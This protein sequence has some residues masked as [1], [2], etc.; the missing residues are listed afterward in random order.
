MN[1]DKIPELHRPEVKKGIQRLKETGRLEWIYLVQMANSWGGLD[2]TPA[3]EALK[4]T[5]VRREILNIEKYS[6]E[7]CGCS[8]L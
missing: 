3:T 8:P 2:S 1:E 5:L 6:R 7:V 4:H